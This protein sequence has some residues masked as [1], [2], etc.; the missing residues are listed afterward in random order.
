MPASNQG[1][2]SIARLGQPGKRLFTAPLLINR[3][4]GA[5]QDLRKGK[6]NRIVK[7]GV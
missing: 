2:P 6:L 7:I 5:D 1:F 4:F 3:H